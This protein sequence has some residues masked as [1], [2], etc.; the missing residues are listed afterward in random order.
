MSA[1]GG[2]AGRFFSELRDKLAFLQNAVGAVLGPFDA[3]LAL[4]G[5]KTLPLRMARH[6][7]S[8]LAIAQ[9]LTR[10]AKVAS[11]HYP[12]LPGHPL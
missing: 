3:F 12:G 8:A 11:V 4:R 5:L 6:C 9:W 1:A 7:E 10:H 2:L